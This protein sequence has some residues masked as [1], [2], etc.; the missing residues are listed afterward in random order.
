LY[1]GWRAEILYDSIQA[2]A[3]RGK[4]QGA[5]VVL[6]TWEDMTHDFQIF[7]P[8]APQSAEALRRIGEVIEG[9]IKARNQME[10]INS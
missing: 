6:E 9:R 2:F 5:D 10:T 3:G 8:D 4:N 1:A 7:G